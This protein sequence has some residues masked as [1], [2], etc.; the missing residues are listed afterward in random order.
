M[1]GMSLCKCWMMLALVK[2]VK[3]ISLRSEPISSKE[4]FAA[5]GE[6][7]ATSLDPARMARQHKLKTAPQDYA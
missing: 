2:S 3:K 7:L 5:G 1:P 6:L 4:I